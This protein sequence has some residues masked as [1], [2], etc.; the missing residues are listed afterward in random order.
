MISKDIF[1]IHTDFCVLWNNVIINQ[2]QDQSV[3]IIVGMHVNIRKKQGNEIKSY[4][5]EQL[6]W[7]FFKEDP[8]NH[9]TTLKM[10]L[11]IMLTLFIEVPPHCTSKLLFLLQKYLF[12]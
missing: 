9:V 1:H 3:A 6:L 11:L 7:K 10:A 8:L 4:V 12:S 5:E 2:K